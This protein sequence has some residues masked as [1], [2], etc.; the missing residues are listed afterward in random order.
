MYPPNKHSLGML[1]A[2]SADIG[3][4]NHILLLTDYARVSTKAALGI[5]ISQELQQL[6]NNHR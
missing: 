2:T 3:R 4:I 5:K 1:H 6:I